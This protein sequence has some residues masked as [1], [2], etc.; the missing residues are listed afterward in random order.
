MREERVDAGDGLLRIQSIYFVF[1]LAVFLGD[2]ENSQDGEGFERIG[3]LR[4]QHAG[5][6]VKI[7]AGIYKDQAS[8]GSQKK[9][10]KNDANRNHITLSLYRRRKQ[11]AMRRM[12]ASPTRNL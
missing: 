5:A 8:G 12:S 3:G 10:F 4:M 2:G 6:Q 7:V 9:T 11:T 1:G